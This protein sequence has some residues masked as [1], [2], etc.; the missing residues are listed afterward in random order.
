MNVLLLGGTGFLSGAVLRQLQAAGHGV[1]VFTRGQR[2]LPEGVE[3][4]VGDRRAYAQFPAY[5]DGRTWDVVIDCICYQPE[6]AESAIETFWNRARQYV[7]ISTDFVY[8][9]HRRLPM[10]E[11]TP[12]Q[13]MSEYGRNKARCEEILQQ[14]WQ[15]RQFPTTVLRPPH[16][17]GAGGQLGT[18]SLQGRDPSL[19]DRLQKG[20]PVV[21]LDDGALL[22]Q[23]VVHEDIGRAC[24]AVM[25]KEATFGGVYNCAGPDV[26]TTREYY[27]HI[28]AVV[29]EE[30]QVRSLPSSVYTAMYPERAPF[31][32]HRTYDVSRLERDTGYRPQTDVRHAI[33]SMIDWL[34]AND[35]A[36]PYNPD[37]VEE[38][39][40]AVCDRFTAETLLLLKSQV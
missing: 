28:A 14:A 2:A 39:L 17:M 4:I 33:Y 12:T 32:H 38:K 13:A 23:P 35:A 24:V 29:G 18:G 37:P 25:G 34:Q 21:L 10:D 30:L 26:L 16:I 27:E 31:A 22:I 1:T 9:P 5:F 19:L 15:Q 6:E 3:A 7:M 40:L 8:G 20:V 36:K 11:H